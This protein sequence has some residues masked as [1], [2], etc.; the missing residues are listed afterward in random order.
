MAEAL[1]ADEVLAFLAALPAGELERLLRLAAAHLPD[2]A[3]GYAND[4]PRPLQIE[5][6]TD[7][8]EWEAEGWED[9]S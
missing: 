1:T 9:F 6:D 4:P 7:P 8:L 3:A 5:P 2:P